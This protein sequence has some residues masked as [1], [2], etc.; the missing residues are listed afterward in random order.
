MTCQQDLKDIQQSKV[1]YILMRFCKGLDGFVCGLGWMGF[2]VGW[3]M[4]LLHVDWFVWDFR[5]GF[6]F[7]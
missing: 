1:E 6:V 5:F 2:W 7:L 4:G 3:G